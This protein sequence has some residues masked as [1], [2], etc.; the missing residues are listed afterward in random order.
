MF[1]NQTIETVAISLGGDAEELAGAVAAEV[2]KFVRC[3]AL[4]DDEIAD[5]II[6]LQL[7]LLVDLNGHTRGKSLNPKP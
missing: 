6:D 4:D 3:G 2:D 5:V 7:D 1:W